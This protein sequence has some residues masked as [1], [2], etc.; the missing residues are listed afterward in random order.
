[1]KH[2]RRKSCAV[3]AETTEVG[4][5]SSEATAEFWKITFSHTAF[6]SLGHNV[7]I[8]LEIC[9]PKT[10][11]ELRFLVLEDLL[12]FISQAY[13]K[14]MNAQNTNYYDVILF[15]NVSSLVIAILAKGTIFWFS[16]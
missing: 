14:P 9:V 15:W 6:R 11:E 3:E 16:T 5:E 8:N 1:M 4:G 7:F 13:M 10:K 2:L 12:R